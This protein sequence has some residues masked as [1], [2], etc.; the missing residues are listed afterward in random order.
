MTNG[1]SHLPIMADSATRKAGL[2]DENLRLQNLLEARIVQALE[3]VAR[4]SSDGSNDAAI[5]YRHVIPGIARQL[6]L[7]QTVDASR[8]RTKLV[9][10][11]LTNVRKK[12]AKL[13]D[14]ISRLSDDA[15]VALDLSARLQAIHLI[16]DLE[17]IAAA[18]KNAVSTLPQWS[19]KAARKP[20][21]TKIVE[22]L[23]REFER[24]NGKPPTLT[25]SGGRAGGLF[26][27]LVQT[28]FD[29]LSVKA[30]AEA[31]ARKVMDLEKKS[32]TH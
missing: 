25:V 19:K 5:P 3:G 32:E 18:S 22:F 9:E 11:E 7:M 21:A 31:T 6:I 8:E 1:P 20:S 24:L 28:V 15:M 29:A 2:A 10:S 17:S 13:A 4:D 12:A 14:T 16:D 23:Y 30:S 27:G 26:L